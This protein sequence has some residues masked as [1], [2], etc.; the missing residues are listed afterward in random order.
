MPNVAPVISEAV[1]VSAASVAIESVLLAESEL[2]NGHL[3]LAVIVQDADVVPALEVD[4]IA[5]EVT[6]ALVVLDAGAGDFALKAPALPVIAVLVDLAFPVLNALLPLA[7]LR[8]FLADKTLLAE[9]VIDVAPVS[10]LT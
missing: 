3:V 8:A 1:L 7:F 4:V 5:D 6:P 2:A 9:V 10:T